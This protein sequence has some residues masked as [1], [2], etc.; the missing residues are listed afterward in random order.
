MNPS[1]LSSSHPFILLLL[2][3]CNPRLNL[4]FSCCFVTTLFYS[5]N[6]L[7][8]RLISVTSV[9]NKLIMIIDQ[10]TVMVCFWRLSLYSN[11]H[12]CEDWSL[13]GAPLNFELFFCRQ[14][15]PPYNRLSTLELPVLG[16]LQIEANLTHNPWHC[17]CRME[18]CTDAMMCVCSSHKVITTFCLCL[19]VHASVG[20]GPDLTSRS[21]LCNLWSPKPR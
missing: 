8:R 6:F 2:T 18:V 13:Q 21:C 17:D 16:G 14:A 19:D 7:S 5:R 10:L 4:L 3:L 9:N 11:K 1:P 12:Q 20:S 15:P